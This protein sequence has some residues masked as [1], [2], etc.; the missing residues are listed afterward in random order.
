VRGR[1]EAMTKKE[2]S[3][4]QNDEAIEGPAPKIPPI[5]AKKTKRSSKCMKW[6]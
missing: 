1:E 5:K 6:F 2:K 3:S 4:D